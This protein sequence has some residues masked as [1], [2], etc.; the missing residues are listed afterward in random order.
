MAYD[1]FMWVKGGTG[2][3]AEGESTDDKFKADKAFEIYSFSWG[4]SNPVTIGSAT[5]GAGGGKVSI[6][7][8]N[9][10]K[11]SDSAS[12]NLFLACCQGAHYDEAHV[13]LRKAGGTALEYLK[14]DFTEV[15]V[16]S[17]QWS[18]SSGGD[19]TPTE[20][21]SFAFAK[22]DISYTPQIGKGAAGTMIPA[23]WDVTKN[24]QK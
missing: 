4:A 1:A 17:I 2:P 11:K 16:E 10:M 12:P 13:V 7:S 21:V 18:G 23:S 5:G 19:D 6:S 15:F 8:F 24:L 20:S 14:Y 3:K 22:V 9:V